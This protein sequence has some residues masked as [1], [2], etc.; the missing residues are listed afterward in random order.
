MMVGRVVSPHEVVIS[1]V[2]DIASPATVLHAILCLVFQQSSQ[3]QERLKWS[4]WGPFAKWTAFSFSRNI[5]LSHIHKPL[6]YR[7][8]L[9]AKIYLLLWASLSL[10]F[11]HSRGQLK[12]SLYL[13]P[14]EGMPYFVATAFLATPFDIVESFIFLLQRFG[15]FLPFERLLFRHFQ[16]VVLNLFESKLQGRGFTI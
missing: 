14:T 13:S 16:A 1:E 2:L 15:G 3:P 11:C 4:F 12:S 9:S 5:S 8:V 10:D 7:F 6:V